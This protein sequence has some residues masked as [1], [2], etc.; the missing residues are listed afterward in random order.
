[1]FDFPV[2]VTSLD[3]VPKEYQSI[4]VEAEDG[5]KLIDSLAKKVADLGNLS[6][7]LNAERKARKKLEQELSGFQSIAKTP[8]D[9]RTIMQGWSD[10]GESPDKVKE[11]LAE[12]DKLLNERGDVTKQIESVRKAAEQEFGKLKSQLQSELE[13]AQAEK[14]KAYAARDREL[15][16]SA[17]TQEIVKEKGNAR[18]LLPIL[19]R[20]VKVIETD[21][22]YRAAVVDADGDERLNAKGEPMTLADLVREA[23][24][25]SELLDAFAADGRSGGGAGG[26]GGNGGGK[27]GKTYKL[28]DWQQL[29]A[30]SKPDERQRLIREKA[31]GRI[32][33]IT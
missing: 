1:M 25:D 8:D 22:G 23:K 13:K 33:V 12:K 19:Q 29:V 5:Y 24:S 2:T 11:L 30:G 9:L 16:T 18:L 4:Y 31:A 17:L 6:N 20:H 15:I 14:Q 32:K 28:S 26:A 3:D 21:D 10:L 27:P 7:T